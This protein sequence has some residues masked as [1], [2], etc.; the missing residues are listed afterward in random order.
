MV[1]RKKTVRRRSQ[2][3]MAKIKRDGVFKG[4]GDWAGSQIG[5]ELG[6][7]TKKAVPALML[8][9]AVSAV[10]PPLGASIANSVSGIPVIGPLTNVSAS[11]GATLRSRFL[12]R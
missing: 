5:G 7:V 9:T 6:K 11:Y 4:T 1:R 12:R 2:K 10:T 8:L 3:L